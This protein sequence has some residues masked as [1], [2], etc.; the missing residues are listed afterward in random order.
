MKTACYCLWLDGWLYY[1]IK[2]AYN[3]G[4]SAFVIGD[5]NEIGGRFGL[6][7]CVFYRKAESCRLYHGNIV[8]VVSDGDRIFRVDTKKLGHFYKS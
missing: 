8:I 7:Y 3:R 5:G 1:I 2:I 4:D 6:L